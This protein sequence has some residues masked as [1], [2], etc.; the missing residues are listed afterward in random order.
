MKNFKKYIFFVLFTIFS[1]LFYVDV[2]AT[3]MR[4]IIDN[5]EVSELP[6]SPVIR[7][8]S[9]L[10]PARAVFEHVGAIVN[11]HSVNRQVSVF[12][13][14]D[15]LVMTIG[16]SIALLNG[17]P[18]YMPTPP[19]V[20][21]D[22]TMIP[23]RLPAEIF[24][25]DVKWDRIGRAAVL[26]SPI[27]NIPPIEPPASEEP[28]ALCPSTNLDVCEVN[29]SIIIPEPP[30]NFGLSRNVSTYPISTIAYPQTSIRQILSPQ[31]VG[32][33]A[34]VI[35]A[36][37]PISEVN[38]FVLPD[39]RLVIDIYNAV[40]MLHGNIPTHY[41]V[42]VSR[43]HYAQFSNIPLVTRV[44]FQVITDAEFT[45][46]LSSN[47][48]SLVVAFTDDDISDVLDTPDSDAPDDSLDVLP[49]YN[50]PTNTLPNNNL[51]TSA[52]PFVVILD[53]GHGGTNI[54]TIHNGVIEREIVL[55]ITKKIMQL[56]DNIPNIQVHMT[57]W[58]DYT[59]C[60]YYR[61]V[62]ANT[63]N[64][65]L[66]VSIHANAAGTWRAPNPAPQGIE[67]WYN[68]GENELNSNN[69][70]TSRQFAEIVQRHLIS[71]T[72]ANC[73][74]LRYGPGLIVLRDSNMPSAL[75]ELGF[76][77]NP[78]EAALLATVQYQWQLAYAI[79]DAIV[80]TANTFHR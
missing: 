50:L 13:G 16:E 23:L 44:V 59:V 21:H 39:N 8:D 20:I 22:S 71:R 69:S 53:P 58:G 66:F 6:L 48:E 11:W 57:R 54:G 42:P 80:E 34:F 19:I 72:N 1:L 31:N 79:R 25:F 45:L 14:D 33:E 63:L 73:R 64:A 55:S 62:F 41:S 38:Y 12:F 2:Q 10:V 67:T 46:S 5:H 78:A 74:G 17:M 32:M 52:R 28:P 61:A 37:S 7:N 77:T 70:F 56:L 15:V 30:T 75:L 76:L 40:N 35:V 4:L 24:G 65:D 27:I 9:M 43:V 47:R 68:H 18:V 51:S 36:S 60:N 3:A 49:D 26:N 29:N